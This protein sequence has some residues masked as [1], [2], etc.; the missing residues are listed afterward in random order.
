[1]GASL[2]DL[3]LAYHLID[4]AEA[5]GGHDLPKVLHDKFEVVDDMVGVACE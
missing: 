5:K 1:M 3:A 2:Q 4:G